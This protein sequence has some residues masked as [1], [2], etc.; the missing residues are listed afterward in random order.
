MGPQID[1]AE[2][3]TT[4]PATAD[5]VVIGGGIIGISAALHLARSGVS[6]VLCEKGRLAGEQ[7]SRNWGWVR[8]TGRD[9]R[10][11][12]LI[13]EALRMWRELERDGIDTGFRECGV[14][15]VA[16]KD[17][18]RERYERWLDAVRPY[19]MGSRIIDGDELASHLPSG[20]KRFT[21]GALYTKTDG[22]AEPQKAVPA[23]AA[24]ARAAGAVILEDCAVRGLDLQGGRVAA[25]VTE[26]GRIACNSAILASGAWSRLFAGS[27]GLVLPQLKVRASVLR[28]APIAGGPETSAWLGAFAYRK[29]VDGGYTI[30]NGRG[31]PPPPRPPLP[32]RSPHPTP[33]GAR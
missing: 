22:R 5:V 16:D 9:L 13:I 21:K 30:A 14:L 25:V 17:G 19:Q 4:L 23:I 10:E 3:D 33:L 12:P 18:D 11:V 28:T 15:Y 24:A 26:R 8:K 31:G 1:P 27:L 29:R 6:V 2:T 32:R 20:S 7:S